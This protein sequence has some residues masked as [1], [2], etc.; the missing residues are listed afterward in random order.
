MEAMGVFKKLR[1]DLND[2]LRSGHCRVVTVRN[3]VLGGGTLGKSDGCYH[4]REVI[5][6]MWDCTFGRVVLN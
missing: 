6:K 4:I 3:R 2:I 5:L 1:R